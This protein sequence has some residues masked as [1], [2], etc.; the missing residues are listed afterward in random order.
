MQYMKYMQTIYLCHHYTF[1]CRRTL[2]RLLTT[3]RSQ[4][5]QRYRTVRT[6]SSASPWSPSLGPLHASPFTQAVVRAMRKLYPESL[7]DKTFDNTGLLLEVP[8]DSLCPPNHSVLLTVDL[9]R[10][11][12]IEAVEREASI[13][14]AYHPIIFRGLKS[15]TLGDPQQQSLLQLAQQ[16]ISVYSPHT[17]VDAVPGGMADW[18][19]DIVVSHSASRSTKLGSLKP[20]SPAPGSPRYSTLEYPQAVEEPSDISVVDHSRRTIHPCPSPVPEGFESAGMGRVVTFFSPEAL[21]SLI[22]RIGNGIGSPSGIAVAVP[23][24]ATVDTMQIRTVGVC[25]GSGAGVLMKGA[26]ELPD[27]LLTGELSHHDALSAIERGS[28]VI[29]LFHSNTE[30]GYLR[31]CMQD[32]LR[33]ALREELEL[34]EHD[35]LNG[36]GE[37]FSVDVSQV[38]RDPYGISIR[39]E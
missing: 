13:I 31:A 8:F 14:I 9:T 10:A 20:L 36:I 24:S 29:T 26:Q 34:S 38:D 2:Q 1:S 17:A 18:L 11:V 33:H 5:G 22:D 19:C 4:Q 32:K 6:M 27:L 15:L 39:M 21:G 30:R 23:Q 25:P 16:G 35:E 37:D 7:A 3:Q 28:A 12:A